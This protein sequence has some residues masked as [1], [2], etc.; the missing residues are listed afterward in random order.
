MTTGSPPPPPGDSAF[1]AGAAFQT[2]DPDLEEDLPASRPVGTTTF[3]RA[4]RSGHALRRALAKG[5]ALKARCSMAC[6]V[7]ARL[8]L[9]HGLGRRVR[10]V[11]REP[12]MV[13]KGS[14]RLGRAGSKSFR[15][16]F[17]RRAKRRLKLVRKVRLHSTS[18]TPRPADRQEH[19]RSPSRAQSPV[20]TLPG[21]TLKSRKAR[22]RHPPCRP[23]ERSG[24]RRARP[25][26]CSSAP[27]G[28]RR[29]TRWGRPVRAGRRAER[30]RARACVV[31]ARRS[32]SARGVLRSAGVKAA[33]R[34]GC[35]PRTQSRTYR[36]DTPW[37]RAC[38][39]RA[40]SYRPRPRSRTRPPCPGAGS[41]L[42]ARR[43]PPR[44]SRGG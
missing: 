5:I 13:A 36:V 2:S 32:T 20:A 24:A 17:T 42:P 3:G 6:R 31:S 12:I 9:R 29:A 33:V 14:A 43:S 10:I 26:A 16:R 8:Y 35:P 41:P 23:G 19:A 44:R 7:T 22:V 30:R 34:E 18:P 25:G 21:A 37:V 39:D 1:A 40:R 38:R 4:G 11:R 28:G 27:A 15:I